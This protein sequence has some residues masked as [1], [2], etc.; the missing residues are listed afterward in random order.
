MLAGV[1]R[2]ADYLNAPSPKPQLT[3]VD[4]TTRSSHFVALGG[5]RG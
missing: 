2:T 4:F 3:I 5:Q 1:L